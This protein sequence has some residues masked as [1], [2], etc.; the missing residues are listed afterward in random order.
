MTIRPIQEN[1]SPKIIWHGLEEW[2][3]VIRKDYKE[4]E[5]KGTVW[6]VAEENGEPIGQVLA[7]MKGKH[8]KPHLWALRVRD[9]HRNKGI[10]TALILR[11]EEVLKNRGATIVTIDVDTWNENAIRLYERVGYKRTGRERKEHWT[12]N[13][14]GKVIE[15]DIILFDLE[16]VL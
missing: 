2:E 5:E 6:L 8:G 16:K 4:M 7:T 11:A 15:E 3:E 12:R 10:G 9:D 1:D 14:N 13:Y